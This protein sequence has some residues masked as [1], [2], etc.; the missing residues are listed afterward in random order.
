[1]SPWSA[2]RALRLPSAWMRWEFA[3]PSS[4]AIAPMCGYPWLLP[5]GRDCPNRSRPTRCT[6]CSNARPALERRRPPAIGSRLLSEFG[7]Q[8]RRPECD[9]GAI[10]QG[11]RHLSAG[12]V[13]LDVTEEL[14]PG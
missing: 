5:T 13:D 10:A 9:V 3:S 2:R 14:H 7:I 8:R 12:A 4:P 11:H 1:M 6:P